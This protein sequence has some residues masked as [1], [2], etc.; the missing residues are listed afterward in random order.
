MNPLEERMAAL[1]AR[2][3]ERAREERVAIAEAMD[4]ALARDALRRRG[5][6]IAGTAGLFGF[7]EI[8]EDAKALEE[9]IDEDASD[10]E[11]RALAAA[12]ERQLAQL[13]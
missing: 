7:D 5:H 13:G 4:G 1:R 12:L 6:S 10:R 8:G 2:F 11:V 3:V 9:A